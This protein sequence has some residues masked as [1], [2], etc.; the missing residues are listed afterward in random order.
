VEEEQL[1]LAYLRGDERAFERLFA[2]LAPRVHALFMRMFRDP[3][4]ADD[5]LQIT[6]LKLHRAR[7]R[8]DP[9]QRV[10]PWVLAIAGRVGID[11]LRRRKAVLEDAAEG[12]LERADES[13]ALALSR[14]VDRL[15][16]AEL[17]K[18]VHAA[19]ERLTEAQRLV[20]HLHRFEE[21]TFAQIAQALDST[22]GAVKLRAFRAYAQLRKLLAPLLESERAA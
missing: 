11:E 5:M 21:L 20:I 7:D 3:A 1:M 17:N 12:A 14:R 4:T 13:A 18:M 22:E 6:F 8:Y 10:R 15:E 2:G 19:L 9:S 16:T